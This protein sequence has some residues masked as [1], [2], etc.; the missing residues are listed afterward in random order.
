[1]YS[2]YLGETFEFAASIEEDGYAI[3][4]T[5]KI[6]RHRHFLY[7]YLL[8]QVG[9]PGLMGIAIKMWWALFG[10]AHLQV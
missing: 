2:F 8:V 6:K 5:S 4:K 3:P 10:I 1:M 7:S 9:S